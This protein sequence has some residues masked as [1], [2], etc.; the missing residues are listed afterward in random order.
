MTAPADGGGVSQAKTARHDSG[1]YGGRPYVKFVN[2]PE[3]KACSMGSRG[4]RAMPMAT[5]QESTKAFPIY[6]LVPRGTQA[7][8]W[9][10]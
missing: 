10:D 3:L 1:R 2:Q 6:G 8:A 7:Y 9:R 4:A 5:T